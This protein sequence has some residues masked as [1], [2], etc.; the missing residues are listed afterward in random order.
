MSNARLL[1]RHL[2]KPD[3]RGLYSFRIHLIVQV[4]RDRGNCKD[5]EFSNLFIQG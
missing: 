5:Y 4:L 2:P 3:F 1:Q